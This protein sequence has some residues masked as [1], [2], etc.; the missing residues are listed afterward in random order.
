MPQDWVNNDETSE[1]TTVKQGMINLEQKLDTLRSSFSGTDFPS[2]TDRQVSQQCWR[3]DT[4]ETEGVGLYRLLTKDADPVND[5]WNFIHG[6]AATTVFGDGFRSVADAAA[7]RTLIGLGTVSTL[8]SGTGAG[9]VRT[10]TLNESIFLQKSDNLA[11]LTNA[12]TART[13]L[14]LDA[15]A[16]LATI[17]S[18]QVDAGA[19]VRAGLA[20]IEKSMTTVAKSSTYTANAMEH[21]F[22]SGGSGWTLSLPPSPSAGERV[23]A[24]L[25]SVAIAG[26]GVQ[27]D[28][29]GNTISGWDALGK[30]IVPNDQV[31]LIFDGSVWS[32]IAS[33]LRSHRA[34]MEVS[35]FTASVGST[36][37]SAPFDAISFDNCGMADIT[38]DRLT[39]VRDGVYAIH[40]L[41]SSGQS[42]PVHLDAEIT[43][44]GTR[45]W[46]NVKPN[47]FDINNPNTTQIDILGHLDLNASD[48]LQLR[49]RDS[50]VATGSARLSAI[51]IR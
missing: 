8:A 3:T 46:S 9:E 35:S 16:T 31:E 30:L 40:G 29:N 36:Y 10:N 41:I 26:N 32:P 47:V 50:I 11:A 2:D 21:V 1:G 17:G 6:N 23:S 19:I 42:G 12:A 45:V 22:C 25:L 15:L 34:Q 20:T 18:A 24:N 43:L 5:V 49:H 38:S 51:E 37:T 27:L 7:G 13:N 48:Y 14:G 44:N 28:G 33:Q 39:I 4:G